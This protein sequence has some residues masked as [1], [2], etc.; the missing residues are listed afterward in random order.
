MIGRQ[1]IITKNAFTLEELNAFMKERWD[2]GCYNDFLIGKP[3]PG[4]VENYILLPATQ[5]FMVIV[6]PRKAGWMLSRK[7]KVILTICNTPSGAM[8]SLA[9]SIRTSSMFVGWWKISTV[10]SM[11][12]ERRGPAEEALQEY[13]AYMHGLLK[14]AGYAE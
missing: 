7:N 5:R 4:S 12:K 3:T 10:M 6:Y 14:A 13:T 1:E 8:Q 11:E 2:T 9:S